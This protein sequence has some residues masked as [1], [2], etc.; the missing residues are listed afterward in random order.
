MLR[1]TIADEGGGR[2]VG[3]GRGKGWRVRVR[4]LNFFFTQWEVLTFVFIALSLG[5]EKFRGVFRVIGNTRSKPQFYQA[6]IPVLRD[7]IYV[8]C[9]ALRIRTCY[10]KGLVLGALV[11]RVI[12]SSVYSP[13]SL[14]PYARNLA[15]LQFS[16]RL[17]GDIDDSYAAN[18]TLTSTRSFCRHQ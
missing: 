7:L 18:A 12:R 1:I 6:I 13:F 5:A 16:A 2:P 14:L 3:G 8:A 15:T 9:L 11:L 10:A 4:N 17:D